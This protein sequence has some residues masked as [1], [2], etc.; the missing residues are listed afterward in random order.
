MFDGNKIAQKERNMRRQ[1][2]LL[3][4]LAFHLIFFSAAGLFQMVFQN[5]TEAFLPTIQIDMVALP[6]QTKNPDNNPID[7]TKQVKE[8]VKPTPPEP[9]APKEER[10]EFAEEKKPPKKDSEKKAQSALERLREEVEKERKRKEDLLAKKKKDDLKK[11]EDQYRAPIRGNQVN[12]GTSTSGVMAA[13]MNAYAGHVVDRVRSNWGLPPYLSNQGLR[14]EVRIFIDSSGN[15]LRYQFT[16][17]SG[18]QV[19]DDYVKA[20]IT[21]AAPF[22]PPPAEMSRGLRS[23][24]IDL[25]FPL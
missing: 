22:A 25:Q 7:F 17:A 10:M 5:H 14:A 11:F 9:N 3:L 20:S 24:G 8:N 13:T 18:N 1:R 23:G 21:R 4:S 6:D 19:F 15:L 2:Y 16:Q 12:Q